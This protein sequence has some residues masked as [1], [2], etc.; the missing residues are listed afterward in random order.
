MPALSAFNQGT[1]EEPEASTTLLVQVEDLEA[2]EPIIL[3]G[4]GIEKVRSLTV[5]GLSSAF[6]GGL[7]DSIRNYPKGSDIFLFTKDTVVG[8]PRSVR[9]NSDEYLNPSSNN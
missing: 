9:V 2:G 7:T 1:D 3:S 5:N 8:L 6:W 4:P